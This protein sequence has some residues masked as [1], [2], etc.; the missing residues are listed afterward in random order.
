[1]SL[2][3]GK[4]HGYFVLAIPILRM[5]ELILKKNTE[6]LTK[7]SGLLTYRSKIY[8]YYSDEYEVG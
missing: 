1:M 7:G 2:R 3:S 5:R 4:E 6:R 8:G